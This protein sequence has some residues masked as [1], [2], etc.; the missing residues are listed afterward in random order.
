MAS[1]SDSF[2]GGDQNPLAGN[3]ESITASGLQ[4]ISGVVKAASSVL[5]A[6]RWKTTTNAFGANQFSQVKILTPGASDDAGVMVRSASTGGGRGYALSYSLGD[7]RIYLRKMTAGAVGAALVAPVVTLSS[8]DTIKVVA[9]TSGADCV[10][11]VYHQGVLMDTYTD[12]SSPYT[13][14]NPGM[15]YQF[16]NT[17]ATGLDDWAG[18]DGSEPAVGG[19]IKRLLLLGV[20]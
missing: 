20:G 16:D 11:D 7:G 17:N 19:T 14:G 13:D 15:V 5:C 6:A 9:T 8:G 10:L 18:G 12:T 4:I 1:A 2:S 3:W